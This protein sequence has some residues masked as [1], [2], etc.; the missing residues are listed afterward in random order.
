M[1]IDVNYRCKPDSMWCKQM[2][3]GGLCD[4]SIKQL[5]CYFG[6]G[7]DKDSSRIKEIHLSP[8]SVA[9]GEGRPFASEFAPS[10]IFMKPL[11]VR[12]CTSGK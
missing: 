12:P 10:V 8:P 3:A 4:T 7:C 9:S 1:V 11:I 5:Y 6:F 2:D